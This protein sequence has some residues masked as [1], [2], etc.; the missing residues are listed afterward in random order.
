MRDLIPGVILAIGTVAFLAGP[1]ALYH[2]LS[3]KRADRW[4]LRVQRWLS[5]EGSAYRG[6]VRTQVD[7]GK[8][9][10]LVV[11]TSIFSIYLGMGWLPSAPLVLLGMAIELYDGCGVGGATLLG[12][13][14]MALSVAVLVCGVK[15][16]RKSPNAA[17]WA[18]K[19]GLWALVHN[20]VVVLTVFAGSMVRGSDTLSDFGVARGLGGA[21]LGYALVSFI[22]AALLL[23]A[24]RVVRRA[25]E[26]R[27]RQDAELAGAEPITAPVEA[28][29]MAPSELGPAPAWP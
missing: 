7:P 25:D 14:G 3:K 5:T 22:H 1:A 19:V 27:A 11:G 20:V 24:A 21:A 9:P 29:P 16:A 23:E 2:L 8:A 6:G 18:R 4:P 12:I 13:P 10:G 26:V 17:A 28:A 15:L